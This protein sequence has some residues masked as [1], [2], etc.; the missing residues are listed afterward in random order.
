MRV[1]LF[2]PPVLSLIFTVAAAADLR[3]PVSLDSDDSCDISVAPAATLLLPFFEVDL[4]APAGQG[5]TTVFTVINTSGV[6]QVAHVVLWT[7]YAF[8]LLN[9]NVFL[10]GY[11]IQTINLYD[12]LV[13]GRI[14]PPNGTGSTASPEGEL[15]D[16]DN[17]LVDEAA[18]ANIPAALSPAALARVQ[19]ALTLGRIAQSG[20]EP[21]CNTVGGIH[22]NAIGYATIDVFTGCADVLPNEPAYFGRWIGF[23]NVLT[24]DYQQVNGHQNYAQANPLVHIRA[25]PEG[26]DAITRANEPRAYTVNLPR[27]FYSRYQSSARPRFDARQPLPSLFAAR[28]IS[29]DPAYFQTYFKIWREGRIG[30]TPSCSLYPDNAT[31]GMVDVVRF[32]EDENPTTL[33][34]DIIICTPIET[35]PTT[36]TTGLL[37]AADAYFFPYNATGA[38]SGWMY[39]NLDYCWRDAPASQN[40]VVVSMRNEGRYSVDFDAAYLGNGCTPP[41]LQSNANDSSGAPIGPAA[42]T[43][44]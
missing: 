25:T 38:L 36:A 35:Y 4:E 13:R 7:D 28:W 3:H 16:S 41:V 37:S 34:P 42:N 23:D 43:N 1:R 40:W 17:A 44:P 27:T 30:I 15:S 26:G 24:G 39:L 18:C 19:S 11:D 9:F 5:E 2:L 33:S 6:T 12:V 29:G 8:P 22:Q 21:A 31:L 32:D 20:N 14:A 10:T